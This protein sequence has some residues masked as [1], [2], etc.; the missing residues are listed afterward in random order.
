M[1]GLGSDNYATFSG[2]SET[3]S[4]LPKL[5]FQAA[6]RPDQAGTNPSLVV[7]TLFNPIARR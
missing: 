6:G 2:R 4:V 1:I 5:L 3:S 7:L